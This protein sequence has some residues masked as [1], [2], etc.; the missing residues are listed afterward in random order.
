[1]LLDEAGGEIDGA[2]EVLPRL[3][4]VRVVGTREPRD[5]DRG[6]ERVASDVV[7]RAERIALALDD[8]RGRPQRG[9]MLR[10]QFLRLPRRMKR[11]A[12]ADEGA[13]PQLLP[14]HAGP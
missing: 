1:M 10:P 7:A 2:R 8:E 5:L 4:L 12:E 14:H 13:A 11:I 3:R 6:R 9:E